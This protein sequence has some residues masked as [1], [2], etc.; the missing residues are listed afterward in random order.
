MLIQI[1]TAGFKLILFILVQ[2]SMILVLIICFRKPFFKDMIN[3]LTLC[4][5]HWFALF[6]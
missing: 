3:Y 2:D 6:F 4:S 5:E 1:S